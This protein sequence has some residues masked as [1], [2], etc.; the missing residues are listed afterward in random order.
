MQIL[1]LL[2]FFSR[3]DYYLTMSKIYD[4]SPEISNSIA[5]WPGD[6]A[7][8]HVINMDTNK[9]DH[10]TLSSIMST[11][12][13]G[14]HTDAPNHYYKT[15]KGISEVS[16]DRYIG[17]AQVININIPLNSRIKPKDIEHINISA[18]RVLFRT[19]SFPD[20]NNWNDDF[21]AL[22]S[23]LINYLAKNAVKLVG[24]DTP[25]I[26]LFDDKVLESHNAVFHHDMSILEGIVLS[27]ITEG[28]YELIA[29]P[30][31]IKGADASPV[32][33]ILREI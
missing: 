22:S 4:I 14:A 23:E 3:S 29:I 32:R 30:L 33:A 11:L 10:I 19:S 7:F 12:H 28:I 25:S 2:T 13:L 17:K 8:K 26:D 16:L 20:P 6:T 31:K 9:G 21:N 15:S 27:D 5:V 1:L 18:N 24:I